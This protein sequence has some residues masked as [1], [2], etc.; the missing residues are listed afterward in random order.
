[1]MQGNGST[2]AVA[3][4]CENWILTEYERTVETVMI[5]FV[6]LVKGSCTSRIFFFTGGGAHVVY[7]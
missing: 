2:Y 6:R 4:V 1:M 7:V 5:T 3:W